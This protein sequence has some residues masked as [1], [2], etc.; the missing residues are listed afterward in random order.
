MAVNRDCVVDTT[1]YW[2]GVPTEGAAYYLVA[3]INSDAVRDALAPLMPKGQFGARHVHKHIWR[4]PIPEYDEENALHREIAQ[5]G[6]V[7]AEG[8]VAVLR[9]LRTARAERGQDTSVTVAR[10]EIRKWLAA[11]TEGQEIDHLVAQ[12][13]R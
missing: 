11:S 6:A 5:A 10:R 1:L 9:D 12:L 3:V 2:I 7:A 8:A 13:L 4:L